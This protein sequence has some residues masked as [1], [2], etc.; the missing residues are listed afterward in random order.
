MSCNA[1]GDEVHERVGNLGCGP[2]AVVT[3]PLRHP[4]D[5]TQQR[6]YGELGVAGRDAAVLDPLLDQ[7]A[8]APSASSRRR[9]S[10]RDWSGSNALSSSN[11]TGC[12]SLPIKYSR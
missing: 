7:L 8:E 11:T 3:I 4:V 6:E 1:A 5:R 9:M 10:A 12:P 2:F